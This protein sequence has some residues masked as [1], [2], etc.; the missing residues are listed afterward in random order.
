MDTRTPFTQPQEECYG[1]VIIITN[2]SRATHVLQ[3][4]KGQIPSVEEAVSTR[5]ERRRDGFLILDVPQHDMKRVRDVL[6]SMSPEDVYDFRH[7]EWKDA[8][9]QAA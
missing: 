1:M 7:V 8:E 6:K 4:L 2:A 3:T 5:T 9:S